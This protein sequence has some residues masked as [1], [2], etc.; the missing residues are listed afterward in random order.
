[1]S[2][3]TTQV[4]ENEADTALIEE[5]AASG[6]S[7]G[8]RKSKTNPKMK[9]FIFTTRNG[10]EIFDLPKTVEALSE[11]AKVIE[12][13]I[14]KRGLILLVGTEPAAKG[15]VAALASEF[16]IPYVV[17]RWLGGTLTNFA[18]LS[19]RIQ[20]FKKLKEDKAAGRLDKYTKK[21]RVLIDRKIEKMTRFFGGLERLERLPDVLIVADAAK[22]VIALKEAK[23]LKIKTIAVG[24]SDADPDLVTHLIPAGTSS[25]SSIAWIF[26]KIREMIS[27][28]LK[29]APAETPKAA[30]KRTV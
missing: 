7:F 15:I 25:R 1:M 30:E 3:E 12:E 23:R 4:A 21:E 14:A 6:I 20:H 8:R 29:K 19:K 18:T 24:S 26:G 27:E 5:M 17:D 2:E 10:F 9:R 11:V 28:G 16:N 22:S 13:V